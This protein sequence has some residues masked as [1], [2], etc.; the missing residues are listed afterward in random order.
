MKGSSGIDK[1]NR[2]ITGLFGTQSLALPSTGTA[3][4]PASRHHSRQSSAASVTR[5]RPRPQPV[6]PLPPAPPIPPVAVFA[7]ALRSLETLVPAVEG[8][9]PKL[10]VHVHALLLGGLA[11]PDLTVVATALLVGCRLVQGGHLSPSACVSLSSDVARLLLHPLQYIR[12]GAAAFLEAAASRL[13][14]GLSLVTLVPLVRPMVSSVPLIITQESL[15]ERV[16]PPLSLRGLKLAG[17]QHDRLLRGDIDLTSLDD[18]DRQ[19]FHSLLP[20]LK[21]QSMMGERERERE[22]ERQKAA[23]GGSGLTGLPGLSELEEF[24]GDMRGGETD[25][26]GGEKEYAVHNAAPPSSFAVSLPQSSHEV[27]VQNIARC[28]HLPPPGVYAP[29]V[30]VNRKDREAKRDRRDRDKDEGADVLGMLV[31]SFPTVGTAVTGLAVS[32]DGWHMAVAS[33]VGEVLLIPSPAVPVPVG[34]KEATIRGLPPVTCLHWC[35]DTLFVGT[36]DGLRVFKVHRVVEG[37]IPRVT[38]VELMAEHLPGEHCVAMAEWRQ[39]RGCVTVTLS[40]CIILVDGD[41]AKS[42]ASVQLPLHLGIAL[43]LSLCP[44][45]GE[46]L[47]V[48][49][50]AGHLVVFDLRF[51]LPVLVLASPSATPLNAVRLVSPTKAYVSGPGV[52]LLWD[53]AEGTTLMAHRLHQASLPSHSPT[54]SG[55]STP[56]QSQMSTA[57]SSL[58]GSARP[59]DGVGSGR[60]VPVPHPSLTAMNG[61]RERED[62]IIGDPQVL[63]HLASPGD[64]VPLP[65][66]RLLP[67]RVP[68]DVLCLA[69][70]WGTSTEQTQPKGA[71][72]PS[73][74]CSGLVLGCHD[75]HVRVWYPQGWKG[76]ASRV[77]PYGMRLPYGNGVCTVPESVHPT[78][79]AYPPEVHIAVGSSSAGIDVH[80]EGAREGRDTWP[81][82]LLGNTDPQGSADGVR[83]ADAVTHCVVYQPAVEYSALSQMACDSPTDAAVTPHPLLGY[84]YLVTADRTG[85]VKVWR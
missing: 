19:A 10:H 30:S 15:A 16:L 67:Q 41:G 14:P 8:V 84:T 1:L 7:G 79:A 61:V 59:F 71:K 23:G 40:G 34:V 3:S 76:T 63:P 48:G 64:A 9:Y 11:H 37:G 26:A 35:Q 58:Q 69:A 27:E 73:L 75:K 6:S 51:L 46:V 82:A 5:D 28:P 55:A 66:A 60:T 65:L 12:R 22:R 53:I 13:G 39:G 42:H 72:T 56:H 68:G 17:T 36:R 62:R 31:A 70:L 50:S 21:R 45:S 24:A 32:S 74:S 77:H 20:L 47:A 18:C 78:A 33:H 44:V 4:A 57:H 85:E 29:P 43:S 54:Q 83:H 52:V 2:F 25:M 81:R 38:G 80:R 49:T